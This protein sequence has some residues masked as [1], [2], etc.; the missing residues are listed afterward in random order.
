MNSTLVLPVACAA[1]AAILIAQVRSSAWADHEFALDRNTLGDGGVA[2]GCTPSTGPDVIVGDLFGITKWGTVGS[3]TAYSIGTESCNIG[4]VPLL[5][6]RDTN[7]HPVIGQH[8]YRLKDGRFEQIGISW[9]KHGFA[10]LTLS[11]C[12]TCQSPGT[13]QLLGVGCSDPYG[14]SLNGNQTGF[15]C[16]AGL[17]CGGLG[18]RFEV[19]ASKGFYE[20]PYNSGG[21]GGDAI[22][23]RLQVLIDDVDPA[24][25][26]GALYYGEGHYVTPDDADAGNHYNNTSYE[27]VIVGGFTG[28]GWNLSL[29]GSTTRELPA[30][31]AWKDDDSDVAINPVDDGSEGRF[32]LGY[33]VTDNGDG[34]WHYEYALYNMN[35]HRSAREFIVPCPDAATVTNVAF[36]DVGYHSGDGNGGVTYDGTD[37]P[38]TVGGNQMAWSTD[39]I[40]V[41]DNAN[42]LRWGTLYN[43]RFDTDTPPTPVTATIGLFRTGT[44]MQLSLETLGPSAPPACPWDCDGSADGVVAIADL[45]ALLAQFD[46]E[47]PLNCTGGACDFDGSG[48]VDVADLLKL[49]AHYDP[50]GLGCP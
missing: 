38:S 11:L 3:I 18:P 24:L 5:W 14:S 46:P 10:A 12:C 19:T 8:L 17:V 2:G 1:G 40:D 29:T 15:S 28:G 30:I 9:L 44:V 23:K 45:L 49:L 27:R 39:T 32:Y 21:V 26:A 41:N 33:L 22:Y 6:D 25:N 16:G 43:Y 50:N 7:L 48:C 37:W 42:A 36:H 4:D 31:Y 34:T 13:S 47:S 20:Y 35:S